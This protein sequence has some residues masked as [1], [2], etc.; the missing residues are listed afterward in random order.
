[1]ELTDAEK[2]RR[3]LPRWP[4]WAGGVILALMVTA[5]VLVDIAAH[6]AEPFVR[7]QVVQALSD[8]F[9]ARVELDS[10]HLKLGNTLRGEW[11]VWGEGKGLRI[12]P[13]ANVEGVHVPEPNPPVQP[14]IRLDEFHFHAPLRYPSGQPVHITQIRLKGL[15]IRFPPRSHIGP[16]SPTG[17]R[18]PAVENFECQRRDRQC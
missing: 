4:F 18:H 3:R 12:W 16:R 11:G 2:P 8:R 13:P 7:Q 14:L 15:D 1:M 5:G 9:H 6:R 17:E 10:F